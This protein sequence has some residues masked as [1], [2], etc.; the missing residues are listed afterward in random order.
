MT[1]LL[2]SLLLAASGAG[3]LDP[4]YAQL[5]ARHEENLA[6]L[7]DWIALPSIAAE[8]LNSAEGAEKMSALLRDAGFQRVEVVPTDGKPAVFATYDAGAK[9]TVGLYFMYDV[10]QVDPSEWTSPPW[11]A[12]LVDKPNLV[13]VEIF[14]QTYSVK[15]GDKV[16]VC[17]ARGELT[18]WD[19]AAGVPV[20][21]MATEME[22]IP[23]VS[24]DRKFI[25][26]VKRKLLGML[27]VE[28][29]KMSDSK[30][31]GNRDDPF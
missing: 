13:H 29:Q 16:A 30:I 17:S 2:L 25:A 18:V 20:W 4:V 22:Q 12:R 5:R 3:G 10:K 27:D 15:A 21:R 1:P 28:K 31:A 11:E 9:R 26:C 14:G 24:P 7:R 8:G 6:R 19:L 23:A